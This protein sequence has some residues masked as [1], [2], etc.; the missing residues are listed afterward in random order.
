MGV[1]KKET[2]ENDIYGGFKTLK[3]GLVSKLDAIKRQDE[4]DRKRI[5]EMKA[6][7]KTAQDNHTSLRNAMIAK[8]EPVY[9]EAREKRLR[10]SAIIRS[11]G[12]MLT[13]ATKGFIAYG[14]NG[15]GVVPQ[16]TPSNAMESLNKINDM[17]QKYLKER[18]AWEA[19]NV[20][21]EQEKAD[22]DIEAKKALLTAE[23]AKATKRENE[24][25][26]VEK[27]IDAIND[28]ILKYEVDAALAKQKRSQDIE[29]YKTKKQIGSMYGGR[30]SKGTASSK[31][32]S[33][34][35]TDKELATIYLRY[36][37]Q[38][39]PVTDEDMTIK[40]Y[41]PTELKSIAR[42]A[43]Q[44][45]KTLLYMG[46][47]NSGMTPSEIETLMSEIDD[48][49]AED[50]LSSYSN[51]V[52]SGLTLAEYAMQYTPFTKPSWGYNPLFVNKR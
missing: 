33:M 31:G 17:Q 14:K 6:Q 5:E 7:I 3:E 1:E 10:S 37:P 19:L 24:R 9:D 32:E 36:S 46:L 25:K 16:G 44:H 11:L 39:S 22:A 28:T 49:A 21:W 40:D 13:A 42:A 43:K 27:R 4:D 18:K 41:T 45:P 34:S 50:I 47:L 30:T 51:D 35:A 2:P 48:D 38:V 26:A 52:D 12:D 23:E 29:D 8:Q 20:K 15:A